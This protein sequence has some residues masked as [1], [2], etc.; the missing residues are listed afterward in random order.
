MWGDTQARL[1]PVRLFLPGLRFSYQ[2][3]AFG[4][5]SSEVVKAPTA[6]RSDRSPKDLGATRYG[7][8][9][10]PGDTQARLSLE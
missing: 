4:A 8:P 6:C 2:H 1:S 5:R 9:A 10:E 3:N 7:D